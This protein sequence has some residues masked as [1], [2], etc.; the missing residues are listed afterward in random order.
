MRSFLESAKEFRESCDARFKTVAIVRDKDDAEWLCCDD[1]LLDG[2]IVD[3]ASKITRSRLLPERILT[4]LFPRKM[5]KR[6]IGRAAFCRKNRIDVLLGCPGRVSLPGY[7]KTAAYI[8]DLGHRLAPGEFPQEECERRDQYFRDI[9]YSH[10]TVILSSKHDAEAL[11]ALFPEAPAAI[12]VHSF[13]S[14]IP[15]ADLSED[16]ASVASAFGLPKKYAIVCNQMW[17]HKRHDLL[18]RAVADVRKETPDVCIVC[19]GP[20]E[21]KYHPS[22]P[23]SVA[24]LIDDLQVG[25]KVVR[26]GS[27]ARRSQL[28]LLRG[29]AFVI[30]PSVSEGWNTGVEEARMLGKQILMSDIP[31]HVEQFHEGC[32]LFRKDDISGLAAGIRDLWQVGQPGP[33]AEEALAKNRYRQMR[34]S[35]TQAVL[36]LLGVS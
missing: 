13:R 8:W 29:S 20:E 24:K 33:S 7:F 2:V 25:K 9:S 21:T 30:Q 35:S 10:T 31:V 19:T 26:L 1:R 15:D 17:K 18:V 28:A 36:R 12:G 5:P 32:R 11:R 3:D 22:Y 34:L 16:P 6:D 27:I 14:Y 23:A 4:K